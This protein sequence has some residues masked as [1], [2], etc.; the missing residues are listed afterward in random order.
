MARILPRDVLVPLLLCGCGIQVVPTG[1][2]GGLAA[3]GPGEETA[4]LHVRYEVRCRECTVCYMAAEPSCDAGAKGIWTKN[5]R[6]VGSDPRRVW[7]EATPAADDLWIQ[8]A[9]ILIDGRV[10][11]EF[12]GDLHPRR[13]ETIS[14]APRR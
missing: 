10:V 3:P 13:G 7:L 4:S 11:V 5:V 1:S 12:D 6:L 9:R 8:K 2:P 14:I